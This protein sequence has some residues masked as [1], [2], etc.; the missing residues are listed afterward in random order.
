MNETTI[1]TAA[2]WLPSGLGALRRDADAEGVRIV[3]TVI[4][5]WVDATQ[6][7]DQ[8]GESLLVAQRDGVVVAVGGLG[9]CPNVAGALRVRRFYVSPAS[10]RQGIARELAQRLIDDSAVHAS[11]VTCNAQASGAAPP[12][13]ESL[14]FQRVDTAGITHRLDR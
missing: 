14:G 3:S 9:W 11:V 10:R 5:R 1:E 6:R 7:Y 2:G 8:P 12:F 13:W 4:D